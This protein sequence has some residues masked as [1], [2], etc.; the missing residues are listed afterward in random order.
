MN[1]IK[2]TTLPMACI[3]VMLVFTTT[4]C[5]SSVNTED[6]HSGSVTML[7]WNAKTQPHK[8]ISRQTRK[9][10]KLHQRIEKINKRHELYTL[11]QQRRSA[12]ESIHD[13]TDRWFWIWSIS[14]GLGILLTI[15][16]GAA[17]AGTGLGLLWFFSFAIGATSLVLW[18]VKRFS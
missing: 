2:T 15:F 10:I 12:I 4:P 5:R 14:W 7:H 9:E 13:E 11:H 16:S 18:L 17:I 8:A 6:F 1:S 3:I